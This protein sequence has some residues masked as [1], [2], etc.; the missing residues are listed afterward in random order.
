MKKFSFTLETPLRVKKTR[1]KEAEGELGVAVQRERQ[2]RE[3]HSG[4]TSR[5]QTA[6]ESLS[7]RLE[8]GGVT[9]IDLKVHST[10]FMALRKRIDDAEKKIE[11]AESEV[12]RVTRKLQVLMKERRVLEEVREQQLTAWRSDVEREE[13]RQ[14][15]DYISAQRT[16]AVIQSRQEVRA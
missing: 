13:M 5:F 16:M 11:S 2:F 9:L 4:L 6:N 15:D 8:Q 7:R 10:G 14:V 12:I 3:E 1:E